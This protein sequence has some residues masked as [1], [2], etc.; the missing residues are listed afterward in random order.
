MRETSPFSLRRRKVISEDAFFYKAKK[1]QERSC[2]VYARFFPAVFGGNYIRAFCHVF[3][4]GGNA[5]FLTDAEH[6]PSA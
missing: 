4:C 3:I 2:A 5:W 6:S 1:R